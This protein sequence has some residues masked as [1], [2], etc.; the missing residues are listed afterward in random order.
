MKNTKTT[1]KQGP[2]WGRRRELNQLMKL[3]SKNSASLLVM[4]GRRRIGKSFLLKKF[5]DSFPKVFLFD[6]LA[7]HDKQNNRSQ[8]DHFSNQLSEQTGIPGFRFN[9]WFEA[10]KALAKQAEQGSVFILLDEISWMGKY[11]PDFPSILK[12]V[13]DSDFSNN[14]QLVIAL[15]GSVSSWINKN[16]LMSADFVGRV[17][18]QM[19]LREIPLRSL[20][21][22]VG[23]KK[24]PKSELLRYVCLIGCVPKYLTEVRFEASFDE[25]IQRLCFTEE[26]FLY[27]EFDK[28]FNDIFER[29]SNSFKKIV[30]LLVDRK[31]SAQE[32]AKGLGVEMNSDL[33]ENLDI[34]VT[35]GF[36]SRDYKYLPDGQKSK[37]SQYRLKDNYLRFYLKYIEPHREKIKWGEEFSS[38]IHIKSHLPSLLGLQ[39][40]NLILNHLPEVVKGLEIPFQLILSISPYFQSA[41]TKNK[42]ACQIDLLIQCHNDVWYLCELKM[43]KEIS[44]KVC[45][46]VQRK[47][48]VLVKPKN[49]KVRTVLIYFGKVKEEVLHRFDKSLNVGKLLSD[50]EI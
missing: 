10:F 44:T 17:S 32:I 8:L 26:G 11:D 34:L 29:K 7:P 1:I 42:G 43:Q 49:I 19:N 6:G 46:E 24:V 9:N 12:S 37:L 15:C 16:I 27:N 2:L 28:I 36:L 38:W 23:T 50:E 48:D 13:W 41:T 33:S 22:F 3:K 45:V 25:E 5:S 4:M 21:H 14:P 31:R 20:H 39:F 40:E 47:M 18:M 35:S 30:S